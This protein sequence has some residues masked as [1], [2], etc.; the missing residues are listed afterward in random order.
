MRAALL[1]LLLVVAGC[2]VRP[3]A[4]IEGVEAPSGDPDGTLLFLVS[5]GAVV[6]VVRPFRITRPPG[7]GIPGEIPLEPP[8]PFALLAAG[9]TADERA[10]GLTSEVPA[11]AVPTEI[12]PSGDGGVMVR[13][14]IDVT[15]LSPLAAEQLACTTAPGRPVTLVGDGTSRA[16]VTCVPRPSRAS[17]RPPAPR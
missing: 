11:E 15:A 3:S 1:V 17:G 8:D 2:G 4:V 10:L 9:P 16:S 13:L 7:E 12:T 14:P 6:P 5:D